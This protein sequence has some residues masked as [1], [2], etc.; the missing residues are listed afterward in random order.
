MAWHGL[1]FLVSFPTFS[2]NAVPVLLLVKALGNKSSLAPFPAGMGVCAHAH[3][4]DKQ[5]IL[6][7]SVQIGNKLHQLPMVVCRRH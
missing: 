3:M 6:K 2:P 1:I 7:K 4:A 5:G